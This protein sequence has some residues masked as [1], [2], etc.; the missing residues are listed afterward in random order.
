MFRHLHAMAYSGDV[1]AA[2]LLLN[3]GHGSD[4]G[5]D[6][7]R[8]WLI[9]RG[10]KTFE[11]ALADPDCLADEDVQVDDSGPLAEF[12]SYGY[13]AASV[14]EELAGHEL[15]IA[16]NP[17]TVEGSTESSA[18]DD[19]VYTNEVLERKLPGLWKKYGEY[20]LRFDELVAAHAKDFLLSENESRDVPGL[21]ALGVGSAIRHRRF[22]V[23]TIKQLTRHGPA[24]A[25]VS[26]AGDEHSMGLS[27][28]FFSLP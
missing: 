1:W 28:E 27:T 25:I 18:F 14:F 10:R 24:I 5:F 7:F 9:S 4:D 19:H 6:Y 15:S 12:E 8:N 16:P 22:G 2:G 23:G 21:G 26:F 17:D 13:V 3:G 20:K 11:D